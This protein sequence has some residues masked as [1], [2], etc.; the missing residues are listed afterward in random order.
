MMNKLISELVAYGMENALI[1]E[2]DKV[3]VTNCLLDLFGILE[4]EEKE[5]QPRQLH[6]ILEDMLAYAH[7]NGIREQDTITAKDLF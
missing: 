6:L 2:A 5:T 7:D 3:Y 1:D 4:Y